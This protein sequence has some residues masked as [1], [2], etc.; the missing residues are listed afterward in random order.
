MQEDKSTDLLLKKNFPKATAVKD[1]KIAIVAI[2]KIEDK[3]PVIIKPDYTKKAI[4]LTYHHISNNDFSGITITPER[5]E[6]DLI[7][8]R[9]NGFN[10]IS[11]REMLNAIEGKQT[12]PPN[13]IV[14]TFDDGIES[15][16]NYAYPL[17]KQYAM[18]ASQFV[19]TSR[20]ESYK[21]STAELNSL[22]PA[23]IVEMHA[24]G[25]IDIQSHSHKGHEYIYINESKKAGPALTYNYFNT[26]TKVLE[27]AEDYQKRITED[28]TSSRDII[29]KYIGEYPDMLCFPFGSYSKELVEIARGVGFSYFITT[30]YG[31]NI[32]NSKDSF[33]YRI[34]AGDKKLNSDILLANILECSKK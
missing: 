4:V 9:D 7:M 6:K 22:S 27:T 25:L 24:S 33:I 3:Q 18:P 23:Q 30:K 21:P 13:A 32:E 28:L 17:L 14:I 34:R 31:Y 10:I 15:F 20:T 26:S 2:E 19:I 29:Y 5:F 12:L 8:L 1:E 16:Y 11:L